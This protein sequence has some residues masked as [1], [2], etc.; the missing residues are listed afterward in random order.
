MV[1]ADH[2]RSNAAMAMV[3][4]HN[5]AQRSVEQPPDERR[6][7]KYVTRA[8][9][10]IVLE[11]GTLRWSTPG[12]LNDP[13]DNQFDLHVE[14]DR[15]ALRQAILDRQ[16]EA[17]GGDQPVPVGN[18]LGVALQWLRQA[19]PGITREQWDREFGPRIDEGI[20]QGERSVAQMQREL[21]PIIAQNKLLCLSEVPDSTLMWTHYAGQ[22]QGLVLR[23]RSVPGLDSPWP[24][25][26]AVQYLADMP[27]LLDTEFLAD[28]MSGRVR[29]DEQTL[30]SRMVF[31]KSEEWAYEREWRIWSGAG[32]SPNAPFEDIPFAADE[33]DAV[34]FG[35]RTPL[36]DRV[37]FSESVRQRYPHAELLQ[38]VRRNWEFGLDIL[39]LS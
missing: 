16:W 6:Y 14:F 8:T 19:A 23:F 12:T 26:R 32:R 7:F 10:R 22:H 29:M 3:D 9:G 25:G 15:G 35:C 34:I 17:Y 24:A 33:L 5:D 31:T 30:I 13:Y 27:R 1:E 28:M 11:N 2:R 20:E 38:A 21:R 18:I 36:E 39:P 37:A 4:N